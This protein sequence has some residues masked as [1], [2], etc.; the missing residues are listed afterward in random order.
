[1]IFDG[2]HLQHFKEIIDFWQSV[3]ENLK[4]ISDWWRAMFK[5]F[6]EITV[7][8]DWYFKTLR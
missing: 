1:M 8:D 5:Q 7:F 6:K 2:Q 3:I 4:E